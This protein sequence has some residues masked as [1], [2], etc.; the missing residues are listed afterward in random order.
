MWKGIVLKIRQKQFSQ[1]DSLKKCP[2]FGIKYRG[3]MLIITV[4]RQMF[5]LNEQSKLNLIGYI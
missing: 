1:R 3:C 2:Y 5:V 4:E